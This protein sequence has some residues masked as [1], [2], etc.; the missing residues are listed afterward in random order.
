LVVD[1]LLHVTR[2]EDNRL[3]GT[4]CTAGGAD[5]HPFSG[6]L[7][8]MRVFEDL[9]PIDRDTKAEGRQWTAETS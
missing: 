9:V 8:L 1:L 4:V 3:S 2:G 5:G 7:E 6:T